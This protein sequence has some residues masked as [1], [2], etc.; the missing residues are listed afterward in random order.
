MKISR[1]SYNHKKFYYFSPKMTADQL[2]EV[3]YSE[4]NHHTV[5]YGTNSIL[6]SKYTCLSFLPKNMYEQFSKA[7]HVYFLIVGIM[8]SIREITT[9]DGV[10]LLLF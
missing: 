4:T 5:D 7:A 3:R 6:T 9:S 10:S 2:E 1:F 8:Q